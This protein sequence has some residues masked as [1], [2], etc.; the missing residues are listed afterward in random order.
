MIAPDSAVL[1][2]LLT[3]LVTLLK[4]GLPPGSGATKAVYIAAALRPPAAAF[5]PRAIVPAEN[6]FRYR[7]NALFEVLTWA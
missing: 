6:D 3:G 1:I 7:L 2:V 4:G 5:P